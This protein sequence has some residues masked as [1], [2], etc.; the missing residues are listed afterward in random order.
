MRYLILFLVLLN[1]VVFLLP[2]ESQRTMHSY[3]RGEPA[4]PM[5]KRLDEQDGAPLKT[6]LVSPGMVQVAYRAPAQKEGD[7][8]SVATKEEVESIANEEDAKTVATADVDA[9]EAKTATTDNEATAPPGNEEHST[10]TEEEGGM[11]GIES[12]GQLDKAPDSKGDS[13]ITSVEPP[14]SG[15]LD[16]GPL[17]CF[18]VGPFRQRKAAEKLMAKMVKKGVKPALRTAKVREPSAYWVYLPSYPSREKAVEV[19]D[20]LESLGFDDYFIVGDAKNRNAIS[21]GL[22]SRK[23]GSRKRVADLK[24]MGF[25]PKVETRYTEKDVYWVDYASHG[26]ID[27]KPFYRALKDKD[28][29][30]N[31]KRECDE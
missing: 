19:V 1:V 25:K 2:K 14:D 24:K 3:T 10:A 27:W 15:A 21:L 18:S 7:E 8:E 20:R 28:K 31:V 4:V 11:A 16:R 29:I 9:D 5:L 22:Y 17:Q 30:R 6:S 13:G 26:R 23:Q 12:Q